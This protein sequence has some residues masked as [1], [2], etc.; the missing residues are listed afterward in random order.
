MRAASAPT[1]PAGELGHRQVLTVLIALML[2]MFLAA[3][4]QTIVSTA[5]RTIADDLD[6]LSLQAWATTAFLITSTLSTPLYGK[7]SDIY[8]RKPLFLTAISIFIVGSALCTFSQ[9]MYELA[10]FRA[11]QGIGAGGLMSLALTIL[12]DI[13]PPRERARYQGYL[14]AVFGTSSVLGPV[15]GGVLSGQANIAG[16]AGWRWIFLVNVPIGVVALLVVARV[17]NVPHLPRRSRIDWPGALALAVALVPLLVVAEQGQTWGWDSTRSIV[18]Y[19]I[20][21]AGVVLFLLAERAYGDDALIPLRLFRNS[22]FSLSNTAGIV[23]GMG[24]FGGLALLP[25]FLQIVRGASPTEAGLL[26]LPQVA[27]NIVAS[28]VAGQIISRTGRYKAF[29]VIGT[30]LVVSATL[31]MAF[32]ITVDIPLW[33]LDLYMAMFGLGLGS[34]MPT[35]VL[36]VQNAVPPRDMG[37]AT[38]SATFFRQLGGTLGTGIF[39]SI[40]FST[41]TGNITDQ[42]RAA[43]GTPAFQAALSDPAVRANPADQPEL[44][45]LAGGGDGGASSVLGNSSFLQAIDPRLARPFSPGSPN[46]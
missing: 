37:V 46:R 38:G 36:V 42:L 7:F 19:L 13:V 6:G 14:L 17:L 41:V 28:V 40:V 25:Q 26:M 20:G 9:S 24:M 23:V 43:A 32:R 15:I 10:A 27:A 11:V 34:C 21:V 16:I 30:L 22:V 3:L 1:A 8:G 2:G 35:L 39:L 44:A 29:L 45:A 18:C 31:L 5:I 33:E 12:G 4:D